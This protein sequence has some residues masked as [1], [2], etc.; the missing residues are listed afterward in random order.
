VKER[1][2]APAYISR[3]GGLIPHHGQYRYLGTRYWHL[4]GLNAA[5]LGDF[6]SRVLP[7]LK[8]FFQLDQ[9]HGTPVEN[10]KFDWKPSRMWTV[11]SMTDR[12][13]HTHAHDHY[14]F[15]MPRVHKM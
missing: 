11:F 4:K 6:V 2:R 5:L 15:L 10:A 12:Q 9:L 7:I 13:T 8:K 14:T 1:A 3:I